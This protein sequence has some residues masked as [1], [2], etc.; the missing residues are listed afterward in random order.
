MELHQPMPLKENADSY[1]LK[2]K[3]LIEA[4]RSTPCRTW[5]MSEESRRMH[6]SEVH[7]RYL[8]KQQCGL[9]PHQWILHC[10]M[11][12]AARLLREGRQPVK[13]VA[14][15]TGFSDSFHF[16]KMFHQH[17]GIPPAAY[18]R[19]LQNKLGGQII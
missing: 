2:I 12:L 18:R 4:I 1:L 14:E 15:K 7:F 10:R 8:F 11:I 6:L 5:E 9:P 3:K 13:D 17:Y 19:E 16:T